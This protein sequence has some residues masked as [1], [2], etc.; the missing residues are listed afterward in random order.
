M[1]VSGTFEDRDGDALTYGASSSS[2]SVASVSASSSTV[3]VTPVSGGTAEVTV[4]ATDVSGGSNT[5]ARQTFTVTVAN[6][7]PEAVGTLPPVSLR[8]E[9][10]P[11]S[12]DVSGGFRDPD[13]DALTV[14]GVA[15]RTPSVATVSVSGSAVQV[16]PVS[17]GTAVVTMTAT[18]GGGLSASA[19]FRGDGCEPCAGGGRAVGGAESARAGGRAG[20][21]CSGCVRGPRR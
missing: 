14:W 16:R 5:T 1:E 19:D 9:D 12:V 7:S 6:Q 18:D 4:T 20:G 21:R 11:E 15:R 2:E 3:T 8:V 10:G 17:G 13:G